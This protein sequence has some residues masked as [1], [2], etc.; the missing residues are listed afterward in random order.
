MET[1]RNDF[2]SFV[3]IELFQD[4]A[5]KAGQ[6]LYGTIHLSAKANLNDVS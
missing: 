6:P 1:N 2:D 5:Y 4:T 3:E